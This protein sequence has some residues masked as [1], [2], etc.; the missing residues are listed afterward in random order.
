[1]SAAWLNTPKVSL[2]Q[3]HWTN[4]CL[5]AS[6]S[7]TDANVVLQSSPGDSFDNMKVGH[8]RV[9]RYPTGNSFG[10]EY[11]LWYHGRNHDLMTQHPQL[12]PL[13]TGRIGRATSNN[14]LI[15]E[16]SGTATSSASEDRSDV[17]LGLNK[18]SWWSFD[19]T[20]VGLGCVLLPVSTPA[21]M[22]EGGV[23]LLY[24]FGGSAEETPV[25]QYLTSTAIIPDSI[26][27]KKLTGMKMKIGVALSQDGMTWGRVE[28]D[29]PTGAILVPDEETEYYCAWP[30]VVVQPENNQFLMYYSTMLKE[31][32]QKCIGL[33]ESS[34]GFRWFKKG[35]CLT[36]SVD[37]LDEKG[38]ARCCVIPDAEW[39]GEQWVEKPNSWKMYYEGVSPEDDKHRILLA[40]SR[41]AR[42]WNKVGLALDVGSHEHAFDSHGVSSPHIIR[43]DDG[44]QRMYYTGQNAQGHTAIGVAKLDGNAGEWVREHAAFSFSNT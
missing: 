41:D 35:I 23:F 18:E 16:K 33:A 28:G 34:D 43:L 40:V 27:D 24:Y 2:H 19:T 36:P 37:S 6:A 15:W 39:D 42:Q 26:K 7:A 30:E 17:C 31:N 14:G 38:V 21:V 5:E 3:K 32:N 29:D 44:T 8:C 1:M 10:A 25:T 22:A 12:P 4:T 11:V 9:H 13:S 20:H